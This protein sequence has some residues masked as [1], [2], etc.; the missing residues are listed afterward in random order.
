MESPCKGSAT[1]KMNQTEP[2]SRACFLAVLMGALCCWITLFWAMGKG[3]DFTDDA[4]YLIWVSNPYIYDWS[5]GEFGFVWH[6]IYRLVGGDI[7]LFRLAGAAALSGSAAVF[8]LALYRFV[9]PLLPARNGPTFI[10]AITTAS[11]WQFVEWIPTPGYNELNLS[12]LLLFTA[13]LAFAV[14]AVGMPSE[15]AG[16]AATISAAA[17][18]AFGWCI[19][20]FAKPPT[21]ILAFFVGVAGL[22]L[23]RPQRP[24]VFV[25]SAAL[26]SCAFLL[27]G[28][29]EI[30]GEIQRFIQRNI[31]GLHMLDIH[32]PT[33]G[34]YAIWHSAIDPLINIVPFRISI[35]LSVVTLWLSALLRL[36]GRRTWMANPLT[37]AVTCALALTVGI[38]R[39]TGSLS[40]SYYTSILVPALLL[41]ALGLA[42]A[43]NRRRTEQPWRLVAMV[44]MLAL[45]PTCYSVGTGAPLIYHAAQA[46]VF[47]LS[48]F[49]VL[50]TAVPLNRRA[51]FFAA[52]VMA[53]SFVTVGMLVGSMATPYRLS[54]P[55]WNQT[56]RVEIGVHSSPLFVDNL[57]ADYISG[58]QHIASAHGFRFGT[59]VIDLTGNSPGTVFA[60]GG[61]APGMPWLSGGYPGSAAYVQEA[62]NRV[63][64]QHLR[65]AWILT[66][67]GISDPLPVSI[68]RSLGLNFPEDYEMTGRAC[69]GTPCIDQFLWKPK[70]E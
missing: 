69:L 34:I 21:A 37:L 19:V 46:S 24:T 1:H 49:I 68:L 12:G 52:T 23:L 67:P 47:L 33:H 16:K 40:T 30:D 28:I 10:L 5:V 60:L 8:G 58:M 45:L 50:A 27:A 53:S 18:T 64:R 3:Y 6:P 4:H 44:G 15:R 20:V 61:E 36:D 57:T 32:S 65:Q 22:V 48:A 31:T 17:L 55:M 7:K 54:S 56:E 14:P 38:W 35:V 59:P 2:L 26:F 66:A 13:G 9:A 63:P 70:T 39:A 51:R 29:S 42:L 25:F 62:L 11:L 43:L 41:I